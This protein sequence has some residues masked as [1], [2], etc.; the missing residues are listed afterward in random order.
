MVIKEDR[1]TR[2]FFI[3]ACFFAH[4][5]PIPVNPLMIEKTGEKRLKKTNGKKWRTGTPKVA[6]AKEPATPHGIK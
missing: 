6:A 1:A 3:Y 2:S 5:R 4:F